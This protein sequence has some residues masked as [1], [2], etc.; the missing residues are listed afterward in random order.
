M[1]TLNQPSHE[2]QTQSTA[3]KA[4]ASPRFDAVLDVVENVRVDTA[5]LDDARRIVADMR[6]RNG[7]PAKEKIFFHSAFEQFDGEM[8]GGLV[9][10]HDLSED[11]IDQG[12]FVTIPPGWWWFDGITP[13]QYRDMMTRAKSAQG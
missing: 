3:E 13:D 12:L 6:A 11:G 5:F 1:N 2:T 8:A 7:L 9:M 4:D 10:F